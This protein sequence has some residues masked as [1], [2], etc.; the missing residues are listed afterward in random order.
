MPIQGW[1][2][3]LVSVRMYGIND[4]LDPEGF[5]AGSG[6][7]PPAGRKPAVRPQRSAPLPAQFFNAATGR[8]GKPGDDMG[9]M[10]SRGQPVV[11]SKPAPAPTQQPQ[12][13]AYRTSLRAALT[14]PTV[15]STPKPTTAS[16]SPAGGGSRSPVAVPEMAKPPKTETAAAQPQ[17]APQSPPM[18]QPMSHP[19]QQSGHLQGMADRAMESINSENASRVLQSHAAKKRQHEMQMQE[20]RLNAMLSAKQLDAQKDQ[21]KDQQRMGLL[22]GLTGTHGVQTDGRGQV[23]HY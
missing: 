4:Y 19:Q 21:Q 18:E 20:Q 6:A 22:R 15:P 14:A 12:M 3:D 17:R 2:L 16:G 23:I 8:L 9:L 13:A 10:P 7:A 1:A 11:A 5:E